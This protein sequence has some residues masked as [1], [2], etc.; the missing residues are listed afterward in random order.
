MTIA[1]PLPHLA[2]GVTGHRTTNGPL[3]AH[4]DRVIAA[5]E[6]LFS[7]LDKMGTAETASLGPVGTT[8]LHNLLACGVDHLASQAAVDQGWEV[9]APLPFG[10]QL[11]LAINAMPRSHEDAQALLQGDEPADRQVA[12]RAQAISGWYDRATLFELAE[13]D[14]EISEL[15][16]RHL[17]DPANSA[18]AQACSAHISDRAAVAGRVMIEQS[19]LLVAVWDGIS[20]IVP[21]GTGHTIAA[22]LDL[23]LPV[24]WISPADPEAWRLLT[25]S[26]MLL[27]REAIPPCSEAQLAQVVRAALRPGE[28]G[29]LKRGADA[30]SREA[31]HDRSSRLGTA[32][33][34]IEAVFGGEGRAWRSLRQTYERPEAIA[35]GSGA[36]I[37]ALADELVG[38]ESAFKAGIDRETLQ[39]FAW[40]D[41]ISA[42]LSDS[43]RSGMMANF[44]LSALAVA[45]GIA[46]Q[47]LHLDGQKW[48]FAVGEFLLLGTILLITWTGRRRHWHRR[49]FETRRVAEYFRHAPILQLLGVT[50]PSGHW[51]RGADTSWPEYYVR[52]GLRSLG[53]PAARVDA[54]YL[55]SGIAGLLN[56]HVLPQRNYHRAKARRLTSVHH[57]LD[58]LSLRLFMLAVLSVSIWLVLAAAGALGLVPA[59]WPKE[60]AKIFTFL[61]V[62]F[63]TLGASIAGMR[64][65]GDFERFAAIS[66]V[67]A[68]KLDA[69]AKRIAVLLDPG[70]LSIG[71]AQVADLAHAVDRV[72]VDEIENWQAVFSGKDIAVPV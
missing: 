47:P 12:E 65:F 72:V 30:L 41:G 39:R 4:L 62:L 2:L 20:H 40:A 66:D 23:G 37:L 14:E 21:G 18:A 16:L 53:L 8:R 54:A 55:R 36:A 63:P 61:G 57:R 22:A 48:I 35:S 60:A 52:H 69:I 3:A 7:L 29:A 71:Y 5:I 38:P 50:R 49:W 51:P 45:L 33:R 67:T 27:V 28:G 11:N 31:W 32:Y 64:Y 26:E 6:R 24:I 59:V 42:R 13:R 58:R 46:Y 9:V 15:F 25:T 44:V 43:Y 56:L 19:D 1:P 10:R 17:A 34:R 70:E 68:E